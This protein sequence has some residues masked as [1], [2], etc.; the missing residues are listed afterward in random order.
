MWSSRSR[1]L[2]T[3]TLSTK[4]STSVLV[5]S[6]SPDLSL[7]VSACSLT[8]ISANSRTVTKL[9]RIMMNLT[10]IVTNQRKKFK[11]DNGKIEPKMIDIDIS[12]F[13][14]MASDKGVLD[15]KAKVGARQVGETKIEYV[16][17][18]AWRGNF[19]AQ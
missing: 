4:T 3:P 8:N 7:Q 13:I 1:S 14:T 10:E 15:V 6:P 2:I 5:T 18:P 17:D 9:G 19:I 16:A 12:I 11:K